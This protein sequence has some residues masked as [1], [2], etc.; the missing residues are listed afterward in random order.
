M[1]TIGALVNALAQAL[2]ATT[3]SIYDIRPP[4]VVGL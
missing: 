2:P 4:L 1:D 3:G